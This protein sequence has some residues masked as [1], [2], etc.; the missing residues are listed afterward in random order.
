MQADEQYR[1]QTGSFDE[2]NPPLSSQTAAAII[3][4]FGSFFTLFGFVV[5]YYH[6][7]FNKV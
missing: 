5:T 2:D 6:L 1:N 3:V 7:K 4:G